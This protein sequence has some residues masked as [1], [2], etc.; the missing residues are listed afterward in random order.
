M[1][2]ATNC[3][4]AKLNLELDTLKQSEDVSDISI[5]ET[6]QDGKTFRTLKSAYPVYD[7]ATPEEKDKITRLIF[8]ELT[9][10]ENTLEYKCKNGFRTLESRFVASS[11]LIGWLSELISHREYIAMSIREL[12]AI[13]PK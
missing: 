4:E 10:S 2:S 1:P 13:I 9:L 3:S 7:L 11:D 5:K 12:E 6:I 8:S